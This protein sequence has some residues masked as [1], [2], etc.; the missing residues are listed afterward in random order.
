M[1]FAVLSNCFW[2]NNVKAPVN[3]ENVK[4]ENAIKHG[5]SKLINGGE[6]QIKIGQ[7]EDKVFFIVE[8]TGTLGSDKDL[9]IGIENT[10]RRLA[11]QYKGKAHFNIYQEGDSVISSINFSKIWRL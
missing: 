5:I 4:V 1:P 6:I 10:K 9:G 8:N 2:K 3:V 11:L 7:T